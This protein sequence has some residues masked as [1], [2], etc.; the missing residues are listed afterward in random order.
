MASGG[1]VDGALALATSRH[2]K[3]LKKLHLDGNRL[4]ARAKDALVKRYGK[5]LYH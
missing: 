3:A 5:G 2:L 1:K 4:V